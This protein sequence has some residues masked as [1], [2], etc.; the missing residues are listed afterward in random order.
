M[1]LE[2]YGILSFL[3]LVCIYYTLLLIDVFCDIKF[4]FLSTRSQFHLLV[5]YLCFFLFVL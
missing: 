3:L 2:Q 4:F 1:L 5:K